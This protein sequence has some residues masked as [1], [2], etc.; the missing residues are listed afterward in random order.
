MRNRTDWTKETILVIGTG[1]SG[2]GAANLLLEAGACVVMLDQKP[3]A[4]RE[5]VLS[6]FPDEKKPELYFGN[7]PE[8]AGDRITKVVPSPGVPLDSPVLDRFFRK[9][10]PVISEVELAF[11]FE[12]GT[13]LAI[14]GT[15]GKTTTTSLTGAIMQDYAEKNGTR[16][17]IVGNIGRSYAR[18][19][20]ETSPATF[21]LG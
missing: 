7:L 20:Q 16:A 14:T 15:N 11:C 21:G 4:D 13:L 19:F 6:N 17:F 3:G 18:A 12:K 8:E 1:I 9:H 5:K 10:I 2:T